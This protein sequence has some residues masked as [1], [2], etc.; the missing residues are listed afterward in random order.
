MPKKKKSKKDDDDWEDEADN[1]VLESLALTKNPGAELDAYFSDLIQ[2]GKAT[3]ADCDR[4]TD[5]L[6]SGMKT[7]DELI[8]EWRAKV[9]PAFDT[10]YGFGSS[11]ADE[12]EDDAAAIMGSDSK[13]RRWRKEEG[14][15]RGGYEGVGA[16]EPA[17]ELT[18]EQVAQRHLDLFGAAGAAGAIWDTADQSV[19]ARHR[20]G[21]SDACLEGWCRAA[22][23]APRVLPL[24]GMLSVCLAGGF[25]VSLHVGVSLHSDR[26]VRLW[27]LATGR[28]LGAHQLKAELTACDASGT[29]AAVGD[30]TGAIYVF[31]TEHDFVP[32]R[33]PAHKAA[34][35][36]VQSLAVIPLTTDSS[37][38][39]G[40]GGGGGGVNALIL[41][42]SRDGKVAATHALSDAWPPAQMARAVVPLPGHFGADAPLCLAAGPPGSAYAQAGAHVALWD[43]SHGIATWTTADGTPTVGRD[44]VEDPRWAPTW[45]ATWALGLGAEPADPFAAAAATTTAA[46][47]ATAAAATAA[48]RPLDITDDSGGGNEARGTQTWKLSSPRAT[49][50]LSFSPSFHLLA[51]AVESPG[52]GHG[53]VALWDVRADARCGPAAALR[54]PGGASVVHLDET[55]SLGGHLLVAPSV[56]GGSGSGSGGG[57][58]SGS[59]GGSGS[60][61]AGSVRLYDIRRVPLAR[62][63]S[64]AKALATF[65]PPADATETCF[66]AHGASLVVGGGGKCAEAWAYSGADLAVED[67]EEAE[68][69]R[70]KKVK[71]K[72][73]RVVGKDARM[74]N[75]TK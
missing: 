20:L 75:R 59:G 74:F 54:M 16:A 58:G 49:K 62:G 6:A 38:S 30:S 65:S 22:K 19:S 37:S 53:V 44:A 24:P 47:V 10:A 4:A 70:T 39:G 43:L 11:T 67:E 69:T 57:S 56:A 13:Q 40:G 42:S 12:V 5:E 23:A 60:S 35:G 46:A 66:A 45:E 21:L 17:D 32:V 64:A 50:P 27:D 41:A 7:E 26:N 3:E 9:E 34:P 48:R 73:K 55:R 36:P 33:Q 68:D 29:I 72:K 2:R 14:G 18:D 15:G 31:S 51:S 61:A 63:S 1:I 52:S 28:K 71:E 8:L 25:G